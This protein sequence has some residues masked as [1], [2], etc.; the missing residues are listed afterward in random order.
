MAALRE[1]VIVLVGGPWDRQAFY[2][3]DWE[4]R[5][6]AAQRMGRTADELCGCALA[7]APDAPGSLR[8]SWTAGENWPMNAAARNAA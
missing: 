6:Q 3:T 4:D 5:R 1:P 8:W 7:Y 2:V